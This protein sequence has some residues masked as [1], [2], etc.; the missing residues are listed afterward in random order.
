[1]T[2]I[3]EERDAHGPFAGFHDFVVRTPCRFE[4]VRALIRSGALDSVSDGCT[5]PQLFFR[6]LSIDREDGL[7]FLPPAPPLID[8]YPAG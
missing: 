6:W 5:R 8:D 3:V 7:G 1:V 2:A 4:D